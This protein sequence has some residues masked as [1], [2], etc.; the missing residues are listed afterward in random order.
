MRATFYRGRMPLDTHI[1]FLRHGISLNGNG[2]TCAV[3]LDVDNGR[4]PWVGNIGRSEQALQCVAQ[5]PARRRDVVVVR[6]DADC[7]IE[8]SLKDRLG[9][10]RAIVGDLETFL[11]VL[12]LDQWRNDR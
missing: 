1:R 9:Q 6:G 7:V 4:L 12:Q 11:V 2:V 8:S 3:R 5:L 10:S